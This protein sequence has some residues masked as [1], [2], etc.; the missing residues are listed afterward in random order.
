M[1]AV[2]AMEEGNEHREL[3]NQF[4]LTIEMMGNTI[5]APGMHIHSSL[6]TMGTF[7]TNADPYLASHLGLEGYYLI[8]NVNNSLKGRK[9]ITTIT[10]KWQSH[11]GIGK[12]SSQPYKP[13]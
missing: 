2:R 10:A 4:D 13:Q 1:M 3:W 5:F 12:S 6:N 11:S 9:W 7:Y 8:T